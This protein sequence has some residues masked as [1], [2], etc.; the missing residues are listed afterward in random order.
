LDKYR[1][2]DKWEEKLGHRNDPNILYKITIDTIK[3][4]K[5]QKIEEKIKEVSKQIEENFD[6]ANQLELLKE[7]TELQQEKSNINNHIKEK[8]K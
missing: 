8:I 3:K 6:E 2:S 5:T 1:I 4:Y 7:L